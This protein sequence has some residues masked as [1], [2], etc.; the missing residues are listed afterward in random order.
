MV[1]WAR[2][3]HRIDVLD[4]YNL[5]QVY[6]YRLVSNVGIIEFNRNDY[7]E[8]DNGFN[9]WPLTKYVEAETADGYF[10]DSLVVWSFKFGSF[11]GG[12]FL[13]GSMPVE[14]VVIDVP[15][16]VC[17][18]VLFILPALWLLLRRPVRTAGRASSLS[19]GETIA[20]N[21]RRISN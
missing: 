7:A 10:R 14:D 16:W 20:S 9:S 1:F 6:D 12:E 8:N 4:F 13:G 11:A 3:Y 5:S 17:V 15:D 2:G 18:I 19:Y 21:R